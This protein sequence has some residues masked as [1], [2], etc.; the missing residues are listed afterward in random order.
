MFDNFILF[1]IVLSSLNLVINTYNT[2]GGFEYIEYMDL[3]INGIFIFEL[4]VKVI[5]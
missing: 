3:V 2:N 1:V 4:V 5:S